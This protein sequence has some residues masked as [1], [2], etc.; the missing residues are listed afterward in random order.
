MI[1]TDG[2]TVTPVMQGAGKRRGQRGK[3]IFSDIAGAL[4]GIG[5]S[6]LGT[7]IGQPGLGGTIG[8]ALGSGTAKMFGGKKRRAKK[9]QA[10]KGLL[11]VLKKVHKI[12]KD[13]K[14][15]SKGATALGYG[16]RRKARHARA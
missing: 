8:S 1:K 12:V 15:I 9:P 11:D 14:L 3:G 10:G 7:M 4:G 2:Y 16:K 5:G 13:N 6:A